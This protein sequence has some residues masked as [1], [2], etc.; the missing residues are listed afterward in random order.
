[1][2]PAV[3][4]RGIPVVSRFEG[5]ESEQIVAFHGRTSFPPK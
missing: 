1:V 3:A 4:L 5:N 2:A